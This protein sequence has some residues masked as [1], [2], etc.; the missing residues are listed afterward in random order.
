MAKRRN[1]NLFEVLI[2]QVTQDREINIVLDKAL[3][4]LG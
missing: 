2:G 4:L 1:T 3:G